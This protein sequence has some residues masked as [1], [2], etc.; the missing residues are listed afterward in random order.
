MKPLPV[1]RYTNGCCLFLFS[2]REE[3]VNEK[4]MREHSC[5]M[6]MMSTILLIVLSSCLGSDD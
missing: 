6:S 3:A 2:S 1:V 5:I 4:L